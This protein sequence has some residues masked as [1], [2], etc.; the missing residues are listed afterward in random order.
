MKVDQSMITGESDPI[1]VQLEAADPD[2]LEAKNVIFNGSLVVDGYGIGMAIRTGDATLIGGTTIC[3]FITSESK[4][5]KSFRY[6][7][8]NR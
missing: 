5:S 3:I 8:V 4:S 6:G 2:V 7:Q 1:E